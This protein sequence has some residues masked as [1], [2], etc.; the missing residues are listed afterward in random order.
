[1]ENINKALFTIK[2]NFLQLLSD[3]D[4]LFELVEMYHDASLRDVENIDKLTLELNST[5]VS[6]KSTHSGHQESE[7]QIEQLHEKLERSHS[8]SYIYASPSHMVD[9][10]HGSKEDPHVM[11]EH[12]VHFYFQF[13]G[14]DIVKKNKDQALSLFQSDLSYL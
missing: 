3:I 1:M 10:I 13:L 14:E 7:I 8:P 9:C 11:I 12:E 4:H 6:L 5:Q 2:G